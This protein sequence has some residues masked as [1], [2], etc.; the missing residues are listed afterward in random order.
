MSDNLLQG[1]IKKAADKV[2]ETVGD[3]PGEGELKKVTQ[4]AHETV[5]QAA[6]QADQVTDQLRQATT[7]A[8]VAYEGMVKG[9]RAIVINEPIKVLVI[10]AALGFASGVLCTRGGHRSRI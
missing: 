1:G 5:D 8:Q 10:V 7:S 3:T 6:N 4:K 2:Q 9:L